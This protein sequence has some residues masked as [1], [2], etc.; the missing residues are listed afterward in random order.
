MAM[1]VTPRLTQGPQS[2]APIMIAIANSGK[3]DRPKAR[4]VCERTVRESRS[5]MSS[6]PLR[7]GCGERLEQLS[8]ISARYAKEPTHRIA[9]AAELLGA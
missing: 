7:L 3:N 1:T 8:R 4:P 6:F 2:A 5:M 9:G